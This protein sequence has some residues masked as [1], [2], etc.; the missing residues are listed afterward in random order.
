MDAL[1]RKGGLAQLPAPPD[2]SE[3][4]TKGNL[5]NHYLLG[6]AYYPEW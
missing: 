3:G 1:A 5:W 6:T 4:K 2:E